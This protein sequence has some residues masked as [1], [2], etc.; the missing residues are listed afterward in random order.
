MR[1]FSKHISV[2][3]G[4]VAAVVICILVFGDSVP[5]RKCC[6]QLRSLGCAIMLYRGDHD[7]AYPSDLASIENGMY[8]PLLQCPGAKKVASNERISGA[9]YVYVN[10][11]PHLPNTKVLPEDYPIVFDA[12]LSNHDGRGIN[13]LLAGG[14]VIWDE[15]AKWLSAFVA[16]NCPW[17]SLPKDMSR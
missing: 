13:I 10:W 16:S 5:K 11:S 9:D 3:L 2:S 6:N 4:V 14:S 1:R 7:G 8:L 17:I 15:N 12:R